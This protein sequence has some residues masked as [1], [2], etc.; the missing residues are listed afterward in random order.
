MGHPTFHKPR[1][2]T[3]PGC[4]RNHLT[5]KPSACAG[6]ETNFPSGTDMHLRG[7]RT[8]MAAIGTSGSHPRPSCAGPRPWGRRQWQVHPRGFKSGVSNCDPTAKQVTYW[9]V[10]AV[11]CRVKKGSQWS[12]AG[13]GSPS[14]ARG[15]HPVFLW[16]ITFLGNPEVALVKSIVLDVG[17][18]RTPPAIVVDGKGQLFYRDYSGQQV[19]QFDPDGRVVRPIGRSGEGPGEYFRP[20]FYSSRRKPSWSWSKAWERSPGSPPQRAGMVA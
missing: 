3:G 18:P 8:Q 20:G 2:P 10:T 1:I 14:E 5:V 7:K 11:H 4:F 17:R 9:V 15:A 13:P 16:F 6:Y 19:R 12:R